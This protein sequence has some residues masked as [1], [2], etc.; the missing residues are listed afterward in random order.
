MRAMSLARGFEGSSSG[1]GSSPID[2]ATKGDL[3][4]A[5]KIGFWMLL[6]MSEGS[7]L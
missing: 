5:F 7:V 6:S 1:R 2:L 3:S 4:R